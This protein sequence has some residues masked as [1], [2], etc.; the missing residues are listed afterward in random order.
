[1]TKIIV[2]IDGSSAAR[3]AF[4]WAYDHATSN[5][6]V[7]ALHT[8]RISPVA[9]LE[10]P[11]YNPADFEVDAR[12][13]LSEFIDAIPARDDGPTV[14]QRTVHGAPAQVLVEEAAAADLVVVGS[15]GLGGFRAALLGSVSA[16]V[17]HHSACPVVV[18]PPADHEPATKEAAQ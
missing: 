4:D 7:V 5:D 11:V 8:W 3:S 17:L 1:M 10:A 15:R 12:R 18:V 14:E 13:F 16:F 2:G 9:G 6:T